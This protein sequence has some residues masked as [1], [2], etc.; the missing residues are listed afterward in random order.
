MDSLQLGEFLQKALLLKLVPLLA[1]LNLHL[2]LRD[3]SLVVCDLLLGSLKQCFH[4]I[5]VRCCL[6]ELALELDV[7]A[8]QRHRRITIRLDLYKHLLG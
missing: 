7:L 2:L 1:L 4:G 6:L 5:H 3:V 8:G